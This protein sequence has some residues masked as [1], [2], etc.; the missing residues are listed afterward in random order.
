MSAF[1]KT[2]YSNYENL[3][4]Y[5]CSYSTSPL[6]SGFDT[7]FYHSKTQSIVKDLNSSN[8]LFIRWDDK[9]TVI[10]KIDLEEINKNK[11]GYNATSPLSLFK[12]I[13]EIG[14]KGNLIFISDGQ[15]ND[16]CAQDCSKILLD[17]KFNMVNIYLI[18]TGGQINESVSCAL[19]RESTHEINIYKNSYSSPET[20][21]VNENDLKTVYNVD[22]INTIEE[23]L[24]QKETI[25][26]VLF[27]INMGT[28]GNKVLHPKL[29][30]LKNRLVKSESN[31]YKKNDDNPVSRLIKSFDKCDPSLVE[32]N[33]VWKMYYK[34]EDGVDDENDWK[35]LIDKFISW[36][37]GSL[38]RTFDRNKITNREASAVSEPVIP[39]ESVQI[40]EEKLED[41]KLTCPITLSEYSSS[42]MIILVKRNG[43][44]VFD[45]LP[46]NLRDS[47]INCPLNALRNNEILMYIKSLLDSVISIEAYKELVEYG[48]SDKSPLTR[49]EIFGGLC[50][51]KDK[52]HVQ[53]TNSTLRYVLTGGKSL[54]NIDLWF[55]VIY[56]IIKRG[57]AEHLIDHLPMV[58]EH[59]KYRL[60]NSKSYMCLS[61]LPTYP[62]Y[63]VPLGLALWC[64]VM[65]TTSNL[66]LMKNPKNDP[67]R[68][69]LSY[70]IDIIELLNILN[71]NVP[72]KLLVHINRLKTLRNFLLE[73]K[74]GKEQTF[75]LKN[76][77][78]A[79]FYNAIETS[80]LW[81]LIDGE[82]SDEQISKVKYQLPNFCKD[83]SNTE[84]KDVLDLCDSNKAE[85][86]IYIPYNFQMKP[87]AKSITKN[88]TF[89]KD[90]PYCKVNISPKTC[91]PYYN[92]I[93][94]GRHK[95]WL[96]KAIEV[97]GYT[98]FSTNN[99]FGNYIFQNKKYPTKEEF[100]NYLFMYHFTRDKK[101]LPI[102]IQQFVDEVFTEYEDILKSIE[103]EEFSKRWNESVYKDVRRIME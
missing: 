13:K 72:T 30:E 40:L 42:N 73:V 65:A 44:S 7:S 15:I 81:I 41:L 96:D 101:T 16:T 37:D 47:L 99:F 85:A 53:A 79:L 70:S 75:K 60:L 26:N 9:H 51:G 91:R 71:I 64:S 33:N 88:W 63:S 97:Y 2:N 61:G 19:T 57:Y 52:S 3:V 27:S 98:L 74:K 24:N 10:S 56:F 32:L 82:V 62:T 17:W 43:S 38:L 28:S 95:T 66:S 5:D 11:K 4:A 35:K 90:I 83:L 76:L 23:F 86:D 102:C 6:C 59:L 34:I 84:I 68:F 31:S 25:K 80:N 50:L 46:T 21:I 55:A 54:G 45:D 94:D 89:G 58:E 22:L 49:E 36:C 1:S 14:F 29:V 100:L 77:V 103:P 67:I 20:I 93:D 39:S 92:I 8:T 18:Y 78:D 69:H 48:I 12:F 87:Y